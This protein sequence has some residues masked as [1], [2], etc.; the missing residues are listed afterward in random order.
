[1]SA[2]PPTDQPSDAPSDEALVRRVLAGDTL[3][4]ELLMRRHNRRVY[5]AVRALLRDEAEIEDAMQ[6]AYASAFAHLDRFEGRARFATW[7]VRIA[8]NEA[9]GRLRKRRPSAEPFDDL[10]DA[11]APDELAPTPEQRVADREL[12]ALL[13]RAVD[14]LPVGYRQVFV[15]R[16]VEGLDTAET[17]T[18]LDLSEDLVKQR[19]HRARGMVQRTIEARVGASAPALFELHAPRCDRIVRAVMDRIA[20]GR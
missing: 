7:L 12:A 20:P 5:R 6:D 2:F 3:P 17:A 19:L 15:L 8:V 10:A 13:E 11:L 14:G 16:L 9:L 4:F 18:I 1:M